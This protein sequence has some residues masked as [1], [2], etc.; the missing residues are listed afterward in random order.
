VSEQG[1]A[2]PEGSAAMGAEQRESRE[3]EKQG[4]AQKLGRE[5]SSAGCHGRARDRRAEARNRQEEGNRERG[6]GSTA[7]C[8]FYPGIGGVGIRSNRV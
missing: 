6:S 3:R 8:G 1:D 2:A 5:L 4:D 7:A